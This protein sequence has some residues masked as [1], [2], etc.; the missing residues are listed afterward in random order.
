MTTCADLIQDTRAHLFTGQTEMLNRLSGGLDASATTFQVAF[1]LGAITRNSIVEIDMEQIYVFSITSSS[2][3]VSDCIRGY[4]GTASAIHSDASVVTASPKF[5]AARIMQALNDDLR[6][7]SSPMNGLYRVETLDIEFNAAIQGYDMVGVSS[8]EML[9]V[10][11]VRYR[12]AGPEKSWPK[13]T[14]YALL[15]DASAVGVYG[16]F[17]TSLAIVLYEGG[18]PGLPVHVAYRAPFVPFTDPADDAVAD[19][20]LLSTM[21]DLPP[22]GAAIR[23]VA[24]REVKRNFDEAQGEPRRAEEVPPTAIS[25]SSRELTRLRRDRINAE[26]ARLARFYGHELVG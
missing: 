15:R 8:A 3:T 25:Q 24:G 12:T 1:D 23:L 9:G 20:G 4:N 7:L 19:A 14:N 21:I 18:Q 6:D 22:L 2:K 17:S 26:A 13:I 11:Q 16:D 10:S 5:P